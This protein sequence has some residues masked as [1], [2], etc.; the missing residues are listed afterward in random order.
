M[1]RNTALFAPVATV[2]QIELGGYTLGDQLQGSRSTFVATRSG[3][4]TPYVVKTLVGDFEDAQF[5]EIAG[6]IEPADVSPHL[7]S[8]VEVGVQPHLAYAVAPY[9]EGVNLARVIRMVHSR[10]ARALSTRGVHGATY[11][12][13]ELS[14]AYSE[15]L[16]NRADR[17]WLSFSPDTAFVCQGGKV[18]ILD[19]RWSHFRRIFGQQ[20]SSCSLAHELA[21]SLPQ[22][23][24]SSVM[25]GDE[26]VWG[27]SIALW[28]LLTGY[29]LFRR[30]SLVDTMRAL[31]KGEIPD[32]REFNRHVPEALGRWV[33]ESLRH[34]E[35]RSLATYAD[36]LMAVSQGSALGGSLA[37]EEW[38]MDLAGESVTSQRV[39][40]EGALD[41]LLEGDTVT[42]SSSE[43][44]N[45]YT[46]GPPSLIE[47][48]SPELEWLE[49]GT[50]HS[51]APVVSAADGLT[52]KE[53]GWFKGLLGLPLVVLWLWAGSV[54]LGM[55]K[56]GVDEEPQA[57][58][59]PSSAQN[60]VSSSA[61][62]VTPHQGA[63]PDRVVDLPEIYIEAPLPV[64]T[65]R[66]SD[67]RA[68]SVQAPSG[69]TAYA[70]EKLMGRGTFQAELPTGVERLRIVPPD[71]RDEEVVL[72]IQ[73]GA[74]PHFPIEGSTP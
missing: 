13:G 4:S 42:W 69:W 3:D 55:E 61:D 9:L 18:K 66:I 30:D 26:P 65:V 53:T 16:S 67:G 51:I 10:G 34:P 57:A 23:H 20:V 33:T 62:S 58:S 6:R 35:R 29:R 63:E 48:E 7:C 45:S 70:G 49:E 14:L 40:P 36:E 28:E 56:P 22:Y 11:L 15:L 38:M 44:S 5:A 74:A 72:A 31:T 25:V 32:P 19:P 71:E 37:L 39:G 54:L 21:Y 64:V 12:I 2:N 24:R 17:A 41:A 43:S 59:S 50:M 68:L 27:L 47:A 1:E 52:Q 73:L 8:I 46:S 60:D